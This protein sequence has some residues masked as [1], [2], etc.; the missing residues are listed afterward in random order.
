MIGIRVHPLRFN[1]GRTMQITQKSKWQADAIAE[2]DRQR[3]CEGSDVVVRRL[4]RGLNLLRDTLY[5][6]VHA[7]VQVRI[8]LDSMLIPAS[9]VKSALQTQWEIDIF[10]IA[11]SADEVAND[12]D[13]PLVLEWYLPWISRLRLGFRHAEPNVQARLDEYLLTDA[14]DRWLGF[15][16]VLG[17][18]MPES[19]K[20]PVVLFR[21]FPL[22]VQIATALAFN[23]P[24]RANQLRNLQLDLLPAIMSCEK[25]HGA[26][27]D[28]GES[29]DEC[30]NPI[31]TFEWLER[32]S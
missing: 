13:C 23:D 10:Q 8:G 20:T 3:Q 31:W 28:A 18:S 25:C 29:C 4:D 26:V 24:L 5:H 22:A 2:L 16:D 12:G 27:L 17:R 9:E 15:T 11:V 1:Q 6:R 7:D 30:G 14:E 32:E 21:L 19:R